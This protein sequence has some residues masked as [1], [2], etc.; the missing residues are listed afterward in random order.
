MEKTALKAL[1]KIREVKSV[2]ISSVLDG[3]PQSRII[4]IMVQDD[5][6]L[7]FTTCR[8]KPF[9]HQII[10][11]KEIAIT[12]M[13][14][15]YVQVRL[16]GEIKELD[17]DVMDTIYEKNPEFEKLFPEKENMGHYRVFR[18][19]KGKGEIFDLSGK[20]VKMQRQRFAFGGE[21]VNKAGCVITEDCINCGK[22]FKVCPFS[23]ISLNKDSG[24]YEIDKQYCDECGICYY[25]CPADAIE[26]PIGL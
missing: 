8:I 13:T 22:C 9:Y 12:C 23:A 25:T 7:I 3:R 17:H 11:S 18:V 19:N 16:T 1:S 14:P 2:V 21:T 10:D 5:E 6:G 24:I 26:L 20:E 4:D 15:D